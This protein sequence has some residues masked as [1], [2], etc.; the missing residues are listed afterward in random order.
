MSGIKP[1]VLLVDDDCALLESLTCILEDEFDI[2]KAVTAKEAFDFVVNKE[3]DLV[4][5]DLGLPDIS[6]MEALR[7]IREDEPQLPIIILTADDSARKAVEALRL[8]AHTYISK[9]FEVDEII[10][11]SQTAI[12][13]TCLIREL[14]SFKAQADH[15][16]MPVILGRSDSMKE[17][18]DLIDKVSRT[19]V[20]V[21]L[22]GESGTG[23]ELVASA[24]HYSGDRCEN[25]FIALNCAAI[26]EKL[27]E[28]ELFGHE[29]GSFTDA[30]FQKIGLIEC[31]NKGTLF[32]DEI[33]ELRL[34]LQ[35]KLLRVIESR[36]LKRV[37]GTKEISVD[38]RIVSA[39]NTDLFQAVED[40]RFRK[41]LFYRLNV[42]PVVLPPLRKRKEDIPTLLDFFVEEYN[43]SFS[44]HVK[45]FSQE[46]IECLKQYRWPGNV[47]ELRN[48]VER[49]VALADEDI[50]QSD[51]LPLDL[52]VDGSVNFELSSERPL[53][54]AVADF[55]RRYIQSVLHFTNGNQSK[56]SKIIGLHRNALFNKMKSLGMK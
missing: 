50:I 16:K 51:H 53:K 14:R 1:V 45:G 42:V 49:L 13:K 48:V 30:A 24:I 37:G 56:A 28:S 44:K 36:K 18:F 9:P 21:L 3:I 38:I 55:E 22:S 39:T 11:V 10:A 12:E 54:D 20:T 26:P 7:R 34:D 15:K 32:L 41:D 17:I 6:G 5:L 2:L 46:S 25:P 8:G 40:G 33:S 29:K 52:F 35:A 23:K 43:R 47:R 27:V 31:A 19:D 4:F